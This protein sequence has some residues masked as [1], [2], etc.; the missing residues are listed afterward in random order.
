MS[1]A[2]ATKR[3]IFHFDTRVKE[4]S[5]GRIDIDLIDVDFALFNIDDE[6]L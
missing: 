3:Y 2:I 1:K 6:K 5:G 4:E